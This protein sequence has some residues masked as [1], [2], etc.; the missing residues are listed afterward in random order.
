M[1]AGPRPRG[2]LPA[3]LPVGAGQLPLCRFAEAGGAR[4][5]TVPF[6]QYSYTLHGREK[7]SASHEP[8]ETA[9]VRMSSL[10]TTFPLRGCLNLPG[11]EAGKL[12]LLGV[13][14]P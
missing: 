14:V 3:S 1:G 5:G 13:F 9:G 6:L 12:G 8:R 11:G 7:G 10:P 4:G 2:C